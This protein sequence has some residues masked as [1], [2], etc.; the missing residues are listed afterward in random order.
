MSRNRN[1][2]GFPGR[3]AGVSP[4]PEWAEGLSIFDPI[5]LGLD[6]TGVPVTVE[7]TYRNLLIGGE[8]G[9]GKSVLLNNIVGHAALCPDVQLIL[10]DGKR[11]ELG[12]W[13]TVAD[14]FVGNAVKDGLT[15]L[16]QLQAE[17]DRRYDWLET[18]GRRKITRADGIPFLLCVVDEL[19]YFTATVGTDKDQKAY[20]NLF[21]DLVARG[22]A[23]GVIMV[24]ATQRP[25]ADIVPTSLRDICAYR[26][27]FR[28]TT[29]ASSDIILGTG[30]AKQGYNATDITPEARGVGWLLAEGGIPRRFKGAYLTD[31][32]IR[33]LVARAKIIR[34]ID[35]RDG[36]A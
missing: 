18:Q 24:L 10:I 33:R 29:E 22:R 32:D 35:K 11:V 5:F 19:A 3:K 34:G 16:G 2:K 12:M 15:V 25:S 26:C 31:S 23:A 36:A 17:M 4:T 8:P 6:E 1:W 28:C 30:W 14:V 20:I 21:R 27:A 13:R 7:L 9:G